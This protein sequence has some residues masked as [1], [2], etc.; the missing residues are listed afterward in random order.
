MDADTEIDPD[1]HL[2]RDTDA[3]VRVTVVIART[4]RVADGRLAPTLET[5]VETASKVSG[6]DAGLALVED[7]VLVPTATTSRAPH[8]LDVLQSAAGEGPCLE[9]ATSQN[10]VYIDDMT[11]EARW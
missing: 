1:R 3:L 7:G 9:A 6:F 8:E 4:L 2:E 5:V 10:P 11:R